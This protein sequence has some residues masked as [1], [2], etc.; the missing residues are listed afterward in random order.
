MAGFFPDRLAEF[1]QKRCPPE[2]IHTLVLWSKSPANILMHGGLR[3]A[4]SRYEQ[5]FLHL[6]VTGM[7]GTFL[8]PGIP[9]P[10]SVLGL[11]PD[12]IRFTGSPERIRVRFDPIVHLGLPDKRTYSNIR[13]FVDVAG[14]ASRAGIRHA[15][16]SWMTAYP[17]VLKRL[18]KH[19][20]QVKRVAPE[21]WE[22]EAAWL[23]VKAGE[24]GMD[25]AGC[26]VQGWPLSRCID[27]ALLSMLH[28]RGLP[29]ALQKAGGQRPHCGCTA[30][31]D[32]G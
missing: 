20:I 1:L 29:A 27:G 14:P 13:S 9:A 17:K 4:L 23:R 25:V 28:P 2:R 8:E 24:M 7:G 6:T 32:I 16:V 21:T 12:L 3:S 26:C 19:G 15:V 22:E 5:I 30:G 31:W 18:E 10:A 11:L